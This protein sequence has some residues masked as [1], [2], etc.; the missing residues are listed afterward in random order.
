MNDIDTI[1]PCALSDNDIAHISPR[2]NTAF[3]I[4]GVMFFV[5]FLGY[6]ALHCI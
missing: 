5:S 2:L 1:N 4:L 3:N 6:V